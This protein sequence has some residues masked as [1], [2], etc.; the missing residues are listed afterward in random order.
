MSYLRLK[1]VVARQTGPARLRSAGQTF[2]QK[3]SKGRT[4]TRQRMVNARKEEI[5]SS[6]TWPGAASRNCA[7][8]SR[9]SRRC[10]P[11]WKS[12]SC[13]RFS[14]CPTEMPCHARRRC[15]SSCASPSL[16]VWT[17]PCTPLS[18]MRST[19]TPRFTSFRQPSTSKEGCP[20][21]P[22]T[23]TGAKQ[24]RASLR[25][26]SASGQTERAGTRCRAPPRR[27]SGSNMKEQENSARR[28][29][30]KHLSIRRWIGKSLSPS[31]DRGWNE[32]ALRCASWSTTRAK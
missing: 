6:P 26:S 23:T 5:F 30:Y 16:K 28:S 24:S 31:S 17:R 10:V 25:R 22:S 2:R 3:V 19:S 8:T 18:N 7:N 4:Q 14:V 15:G 29:S 21:T 12:T 9:P 32:G 11:T 13:T 1:S 27:A 20:P